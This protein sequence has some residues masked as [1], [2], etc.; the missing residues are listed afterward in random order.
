MLS[1]EQKLAYSS[2][3]F[4][5]QTPW[6]LA[7]TDLNIYSSRLCFHPLNYNHDIKEAF[8]MC[9][10]VPVLQHARFDPWQCYTPYFQ[11]QLQENVNAML[12]LTETEHMSFVRT[13]YYTLTLRS[14]RRATQIMTLSKPPDE[15]FRCSN[16]QIQLPAADRII[17]SWKHSNLTCHPLPPSK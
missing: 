5:D 7:N 11:C 1:S 17:N 9:H 2:L 6:Q 13:V 14:W 3:G 8:N 4:I 10:S 16:S 15:N 12:W